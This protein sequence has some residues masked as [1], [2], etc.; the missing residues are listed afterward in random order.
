MRLDL[1]VRASIL[2]WAVY[3]KLWRAL[4]IVTPVPALHDSDAHFLT[5]TPAQL[6]ALDVLKAL[7]EQN[8]I[9]GD[10]LAS[11]ETSTY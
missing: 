5:A 7:V 3:D 9:T 10:D 11:Q 1:P 6:Q 4:K 8:N 2:V